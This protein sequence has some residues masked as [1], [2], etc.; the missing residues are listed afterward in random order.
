MEESK[1]GEMKWNEIEA[2]LSS[3]M[4]KNSTHYEKHRYPKLM[5][6]DGWSYDNGSSHLM[7]Q[8]WKDQKW[9]SHRPTHIS[10]LNYTTCRTTFIKTWHFSSR[11]QSWQLSTPTYYLT[12]LWSIYPKIIYIKFKN[13]NSYQTILY[14]DRY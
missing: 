6:M 12:F 14:F 10:Q 1:K 11:T 5:N 8:W 9:P 7:M 13:K 4:G 3:I 2:Q